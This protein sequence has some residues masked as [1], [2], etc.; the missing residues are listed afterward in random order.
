MR[1][2][3]KST[4][5]LLGLGVIAVLAACGPGGPTASPEPSESSSSPVPTPDPTRPALAELALGPDGFAQLPLGEAPPTDPALALVTY[6]GA[7]CGGFGVWNADPS[8]ASSD[9]ESY[10]P[11]TAFTVT[12][13]DGGAATGTITRIDLNA[14]DIATDAGIRYGDDRAAVESAYPE[15]TVHDAGLV[16]V[17][18]VEG[19]AGLLLIEVATDAEYWT[20]YRPLDTVVYIHASMADSGVFSVAASGNVLGVCAE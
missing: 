17:Y 6:D 16:D 14:N 8:Y 11:G 19:E 7:A 9:P 2:S 3:R 4:V 20:G 15:A 5:V 13:R 1:T 10:G 18:A 12:D